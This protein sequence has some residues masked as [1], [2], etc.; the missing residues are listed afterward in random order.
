MTVWILRH[1]NSDEVLSVYL[2]AMGAMADL[3]GDWT[4]DKAGYWRGTLRG[5]PPV[6]VLL[7]PWPVKGD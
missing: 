1:A 6:D 3:G 2:D 4:R 7:I 5:L